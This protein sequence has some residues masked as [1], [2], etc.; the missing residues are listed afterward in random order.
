[1]YYFVNLFA[2]LSKDDVGIISL[3]GINT[4]FHSFPLFVFDQLLATS[5]NITVF[6]P[7]A[8]TSASLI[9]S[10]PFTSTMKKGVFC[11]NYKIWN[12]MPASI[13]SDIKFIL[14]WP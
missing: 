11:F 6:L 2:I 8:I 5:Q 1:M 9:L 10:S 3:D 7:F 13:V 4:Y 12:I 14:C